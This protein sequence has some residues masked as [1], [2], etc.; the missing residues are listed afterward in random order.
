EFVSAK[1]L[2]IKTTT[3]KPK[4]SGIFVAERL[5]RYCAQS[6]GK[7]LNFLRHVKELPDSEIINQLTKGLNPW[8]IP[9][10]INQACI[11]PPNQMEL[12]P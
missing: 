8:D 4:V 7:F 12:A 3:R 6:Y 5:E 10:S 11:S 1:R 9:D 2:E